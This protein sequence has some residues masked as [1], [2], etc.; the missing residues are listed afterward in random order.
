MIDTFDKSRA[1]TS[2]LKSLFER[3]TRAEIRTSPATSCSR[4]LLTRFTLWSISIAS[5]VLG[6]LVIKCRRAK[7]ANTQVNGCRQ[8]DVFARTPDSNGSFAIRRVRRHEKNSR[9]AAVSFTGRGVLHQ[10][11]VIRRWIQSV[12]MAETVMQRHTTILMDK[13]PTNVYPVP[14]TC[15]PTKL[16]V[17]SYIYISVRF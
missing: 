2:T 8:R 5:R 14:Y 4:P 10:L 16:H 1:C 15:I 17:W 13:R 7:Y 9:D 11:D 12:S 6:L 3:L